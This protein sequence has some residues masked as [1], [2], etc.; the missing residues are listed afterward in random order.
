MPGS[1]LCAMK[2]CVVLASTQFVPELISV[3]E[4]GGHQFRSGEA[5][6]DG[7]VAIGR[8]HRNRDAGA[9]PAVR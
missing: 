3:D 7:P 2:A 8:A 9:V 4:S 6:G 5:H 1:G